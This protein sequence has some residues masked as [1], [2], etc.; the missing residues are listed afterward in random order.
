MP[1]CL[2]R[3]STDRWS[4]KTAPQRKYRKGTPANALATQGFED[5]KNHSL[6]TMRSR[7][8]AHRLGVHPKQHRLTILHYQ[9]GGLK[10]PDLA[11]D[12]NGRGGRI[13]RKPVQSPAETKYLSSRKPLVP[14]LLLRA[15]VWS[16]IP[17]GGAG[18]L[19]H[20]QWPSGSGS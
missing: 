13:K 11:T 1:V 12:P 10:K 15:E 17:P 2:L 7:N 8:H 6:L 14:H 16:A 5:R 19:L 4:L 9:S 18:G 3:L 20:L